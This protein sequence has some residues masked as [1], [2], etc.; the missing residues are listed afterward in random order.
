MKKKL[1]GGLSVCIFIVGMGLSA[2]AAP[3]TINL[4]FAQ[5]F[6]PTSDQSL[7]WEQFCKEIEKRSNGQVKITY[8][9]GG[10][11]FDG[12]ATWDAVKTGI[13]DLGYVTT[14]HAPGRFLVSEAITVMTGYPS[15]FVVSHVADDYYRKFMPKELSDYQVLAG[16]GNSPM[17]IFSRKP[18]NK[19]EDFKGT[20]TRTSGR[21]ADQVKLLGVAPVSMPAGDSIDAL[22]KGVIDSSLTSMEAAKTWKIAEAAKFCTNTW[23][24]FSPPAYYTVMN[25]AKYDSLPADIKSIFD[26]VSVEWVDKSAVM[27][28]NTDVVGAQYGKEN[29]MKFIDLAP[30]ELNRWRALVAP[31]ADAYVQTMVGKGFAKQEVQ[32]WFDYIKSRIDYWLKDQVKRGIK[33]PI[34]PPEIKG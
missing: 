3:A 24:V 14:G 18:V 6:P 1:L 29:G 10:Q 21:Q 26:K 31:A 20:K 30:E 25:K 8:Y 16:A 28:N 22:S 23:S 11:L 27:A 19:L 4:K 12:P 9:P 32:G 34:G 5:Y 33:S 7:L 15:S 2:W 13:A 17:V